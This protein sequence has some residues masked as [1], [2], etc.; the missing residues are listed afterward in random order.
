MSDDAVA[1][2]PATAPPTDRGA[3]P[4][5]ALLKGLSENVAGVVTSITGS[6]NEGVK[7]GDYG[8]MFQDIGGK[9]TEATTGLTHQVSG[10]AQ[11]ESHQESM[12]V[13]TCSWSLMLPSSIK[14]SLLYDTLACI[15]SHASVHMPYHV[16]N[17]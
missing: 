8:K 17:N 4:L 12:Q 14:V 13:S 16:D 6:I 1:A 3:N 9:I 10:A 2:T 5:D 11:N 15:C 7:S